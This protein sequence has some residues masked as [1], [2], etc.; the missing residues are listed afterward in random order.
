G[1]VSARADELMAAANFCGL[2]YPLHKDYTHN[3]I[4]ISSTPKTEVRK[5][6][7]VWL[8]T[9]ERLVEI[10]EKMGLHIYPYGT[11]HGTHVPTPRSDRYYRMCETVLGVEKYRHC[12][13]HVSGFHFHYCLPYGTFSRKTSNLRQLF[14]SKHKEVLLSLYNAL[15][16]MDPVVTNFMESSPFLDGQYVAK[17]TRLFLYRD[18]WMKKKDGVV[19][20]LYSEHPIFGRLPRYSLTLSDLI[21]LSEK[22][23][24][25]WLE[26]VEEKCPEYL[27]IV[28]DKHPLQLTWGPLRINKVGTFEYRGMDMNLP[29]HMIGTSLI[30]KYLLKKIK[31]EHLAV[32]PSDIGIKGP[33]RLE[34]DTIYVPPYAY[35]SE[36]LQ[37]K[38]ALEGLADADVYNYSKRMYSL[39]MEAVPDKKDPGLSRIQSILKNRKTKSDEIIAMVRKKGYGLSS[40]LDEDFA[41]ELA[42]FGCEEF[43]REI[44]QMIS[45]ELIIDLEQEL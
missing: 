41:R 38:S 31:T 3:M 4:E 8:E 23:H 9:V 29:S 37:Y 12:T 36:V 20:G 22:R 39:A 26:M 6:A 19:S 24:Q 2:K 1:S 25:T 16:A 11:Y 45:K 18:M 15:V 28:A 14:R 30:I 40:Q 13:G 5:G 43:E 34:G 27:D 10:A 7:H 35:L 21:L 32:K 17:D 42:L 44:R 33:F